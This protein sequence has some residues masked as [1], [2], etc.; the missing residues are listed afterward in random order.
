VVMAVVRVPVRVRL[1]DPIGTRSACGRHVPWSRP[2]DGDHGSVLPLTP[3]P[4][5]VVAVT[6]GRGGQDQRHYHR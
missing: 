5:M 3:W 1:S 4:G 6:S 2:R